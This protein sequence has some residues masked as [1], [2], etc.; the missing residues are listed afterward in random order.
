MASEVF[1]TGCVLP[2]R[3][4]DVRLVAQPASRRT[5]SWPWRAIADAAS[6]ITFLCVLCW[7]M[8]HIGSQLLQLTP[9]VAA[10]WERY[11]L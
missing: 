5:T 9:Q 2:N 6:G 1:S 4:Q 10:V 8:W 11:P 3:R 7:A